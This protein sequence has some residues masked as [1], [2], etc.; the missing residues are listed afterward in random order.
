MTATNP[1]RIDVATIIRGKTD[2]RVP[3]LLIRLV[4]KIIHQ[5]E[6]NSFF[7]HHV[8]VEGMDFVNATLRYLDVNIRIQG[9]E[10]I[11]TE[12]EY[13]FVSNHP[14]GGLDGLAMASIVG[15]KYNGNIKFLVNN[16]LMYLSP[17][18]S[19]FVPINVGG[20][21]QERALLGDMEQLFATKQ[22][23][24][25]FPAGVCSRKIDGK[26][27]DY[28]WKKTFVTKAREHQRNVVPVYFEAHNSRFFYLLSRVRKALGIKF[29]IE[30]LFLPHEM[31]RQRGN[32][33]TVTFG[34][35]ISYKTFDDTQTPHYWAQYVRALVYEMKESA[36]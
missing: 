6:I 5:D 12:G 35:P 13:I 17:L 25:L 33:F 21:R 22:Q 14:L 11:P 1:I 9:E 19:L 3:K 10:N 15:G 36:R 28:A 31:F 24:L 20:G 26:V 23:L 16:L 34:K 2:K 4:E 7:E 30:L 27:Q 18:S 32:T 29:N 8:G